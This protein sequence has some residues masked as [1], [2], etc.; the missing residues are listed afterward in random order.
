MYFIELM[1]T[2]KCNNTCYYC[3][4]YKDDKTVVDIDYLKWVLDQCPS[5]LGVEMTGGEIGLLSNLDEFYKTV[6]DHPHVKY[7][8]V[9]SNGLVRKIGVD[10]IDDVEYWE[11]LVYDISDRKIIRFY[12]ELGFNQDHKYVIVTTEKTTKSLLNNWKYFKD[13]GLFQDKFYYKLMN[14]KSN[15]N[16]DS[17][18]DDL[19]KLYFRLDR[20]YE[21][22]MLLSYKVKNFLK[23]ERKCC[24]KFSP[25]P[26]VDLQEKK[27]GHCA[28]NINDSVKADFSKDNLRKLMNGELSENTYCQKCH[29]FDDGNGRGIENNRSYKK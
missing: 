10:W 26:F 23:V 17:Y 5:E 14:H 29:A 18:Y 11:H 15:I 28:I 1:A 25:N 22:R 13:I 8:M 6:K 2:K 16:I 3:T 12:P 4:T 20:E 19:T 9:L 24:Q 7:I 21:Q 27:L